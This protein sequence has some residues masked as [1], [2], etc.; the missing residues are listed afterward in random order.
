MRWYTRLAALALFLALAAPGFAAQVVKVGVVLFPPYIN[1]QAGSDRLHVELLD[2]MNSFQQRYRFVPVNT[3]PV[4]RFRDFDLGRYDM[5]T[6]DNL[7]WGWKDRPVDAS[8]VYLGGGEVYVALKQADRDQ[9]YFDHFADKRMIGM[10]GYHYGF[11]G[12]NTNEDYLR[13]HFQMVFTS[14]NEATIKH[15]LM[16]SGDIAVVTEAYLAGYLERNPQDRDKLLISTKKDQHYQL[17][18][19]IRRGV[20][21]SAAELNALLDAMEQAGILRPLW[22]KYGAEI[23]R[24]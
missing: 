1:K 5:S 7:A 13:H 22:Q 4:R 24:P 20:R 21:P 19:V 6:F 18:F 16:G 15:L 9:R 17:T 12:F 10:R 2:L 8:R 3:G 14:D 11:A 23:N